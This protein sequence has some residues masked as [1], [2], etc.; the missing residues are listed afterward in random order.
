MQLHVIPADDIVVKSNRQRRDLDQSKILELA[1]SIAQNGL[2]HPI[3]VR[4]A[5]DEYTLVVGERRL[6]ALE[7]LWFL[8]QEVTC[9]ERI[10]PEGHVPCL[11]LGDINPVDAEEIELE[12]NIRREDLS[13]KERAD[14][15]SRLAD[16]RSRQAAAGGTP[17]PTTAQIAEEVSGSSEG[18]WQESVRQDIILGKALSDPQKAEVIKDATSR[19]EAFKLLKRHEETQ[20][21]AA[22]G[23]AIGPTFNSSLHTLLQ[24]DCTKIMSELPSNSFDVIL[25]DPPYGI[26]ADEFGDS[27]GKTAGSHFY[28]DSYETWQALMRGFCGESYRLAKPAAHLYA[29]C[30]IDRFIQLR[31]YVR[32]WGWRPFRTPLIWVNPGAIRAPW[33]EHGPLRRYQLILFAI[34]GDRPVTRLYGDVITSPSDPNLG[35]PAQKPVSVIADLLLRSVRPG[36]SVLDPFCGAGTIFP[37]AHFHKCKATGIEIDEAA[38]GIAAQR[39]K[40]LS[41]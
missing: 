1:G 19:K 30:D 16:L 14:A 18:S 9:G 11:F 8:G 24:G 13:W 41:P 33:P 35:H 15:V 36:D 25:T 7:H 32:D 22:L 26:G 31:E 6:K 10:I 4:W 40:E 17:V 27:A 34:K 3:V 23:A 21:H 39:L 28:D 29:F 5:E 20:R 38:Y 37:A 2:I 12:E